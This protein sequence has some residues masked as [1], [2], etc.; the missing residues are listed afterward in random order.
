MKKSW[1]LT[2]VSDFI[3][4]ALFRIT[5]V[6]LSHSFLHLSSITRLRS[7]SSIISSRPRHSRRLGSLSR[8]CHQG[9]SSIVAGC[10]LPEQKSHSHSRVADGL[11]RWPL[12]APPSFLKAPSSPC[13]PYHG[14]QLGMRC[15]KRCKASADAW[16]RCHLN[17]AAPE[18]CVNGV[19]W[20][21]RVL[22]DLIMRGWSDTQITQMSPS[23]NTYCGCQFLESLHNLWRKV[24]LFNYAIIWGRSQHTCFHRTFNKGK[25]MK[26]IYFREQK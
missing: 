7:Q 19:L 23:S 16:Q 21:E 20:R 2:G 24:F 1:V 22:M 9:L 11:P 15:Q 12:W 13:Q 6:L 8:P 18:H 4:K 3:R 25:L 26:K 10:P 14:R 5:F 17:I